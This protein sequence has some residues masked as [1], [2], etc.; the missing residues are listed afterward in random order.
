MWEKIFVS[1]KGNKIILFSFAALIS[2]TLIAINIENFTLFDNRT[3]IIQ[4]KSSDDISLKP[5]IIDTPRKNVSAPLRVQE[6][7]APA[8]TEE[9]ITIQIDKYHNDDL[10]S[11]ESKL[12]RFD[13]NESER[14]NVIFTNEKTINADVSV[15]HVDV[16]NA[17]KISVINRGRLI[18][19]RT[20]NFETGYIDLEAGTYYIKI[21]RGSIYSGGRY[22]LWIRKL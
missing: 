10:G 20:K 13:L 6:T 4:N 21:S 5:A 8:K 22:R 3:I 18:S 9:A 17:E 7:I 16:M 15:Y 11:E 14:V 12:Y 1:V 19:G 2:F